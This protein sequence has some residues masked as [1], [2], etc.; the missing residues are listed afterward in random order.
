MTHWLFYSMI[1]ASLVAAALAAFVVALIK[2]RFSQSRRTFQLSDPDGTK[3][4]FTVG[5]DESFSD[6]VSRELRNHQSKQPEQRKGTGTA[7]A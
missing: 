1:I 2:R 5:E 6:A 4:T 3:V 7:M